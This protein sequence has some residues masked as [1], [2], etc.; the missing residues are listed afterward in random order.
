MIPINKNAVISKN[1]G[2]IFVFF[3]LLLINKP[4]SK[5]LKNKISIRGR[6]FEGVVIKDKAK[7]TVVVERN[8]LVYVPKYERYRKARTRFLA[9]NPE[10][11]NAKVGDKVKIAECRKISKNV[12]F[13][14]IEKLK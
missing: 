10:E 8:Y 2:L 4:H 14:V 1:F 11:I 9:R 13:I 6:T 3:I 7:K 12:S 5:M